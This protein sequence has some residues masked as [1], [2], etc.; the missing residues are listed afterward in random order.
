MQS[1]ATTD[2][3]AP[4]TL[5]PSATIWFKLAVVYLIADVA[6]PAIMASLTSL[7]SGQTEVAPILSASA[8]VTAVGT[9]AFAFNLYRSVDL[10]V[11]RAQV[12][13]PNS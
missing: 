9:L 12:L 11:T 13:S 8:F 4:I 2:A 3:S 10:A 1:A 5:A 7:V 6:V